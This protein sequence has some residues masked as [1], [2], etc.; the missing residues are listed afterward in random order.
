MGI[1]ASNYVP[2]F[3][4]GNRVNYAHLKE[5]VIDALWTAGSIEADAAKRLAIYH[6]IQSKIAD[7]ATWF[8]IVTN[9]RI[10]AVSP[11]VGGIEDARLIPIYT[12]EDMSK[13][14]FK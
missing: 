7:T 2:L 5:P 6:E 14:Y 1:D 13:L 11:N 3:F 10:L 12:F 8:P 9:K 4:S